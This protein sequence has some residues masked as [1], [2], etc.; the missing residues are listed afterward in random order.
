MC[1]ISTACQRPS[2][3][4]PDLPLRSRIQTADLFGYLL[5]AF[6]TRCKVL[7]SCDKTQRTRKETD[8]QLLKTVVRADSDSGIMIGARRWT[9]Y[10]SPFFAS[11]SPELPR[12]L[13]WDAPSHCTHLD[14]LPGGSGALYKCRVLGRPGMGVMVLMDSSP[15]IMRFRGISLTGVCKNTYVYIRTVQ[16]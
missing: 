9:C 6:V 3:L 8:G 2:R 12:Q 15:T 7:S 5:V 13:C 4:R 11:P 14:R 1:R 16:V 10:V